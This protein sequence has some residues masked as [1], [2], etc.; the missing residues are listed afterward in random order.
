MMMA[1]HSLLPQPTSPDIGKKDVVVFFVRRP[2]WSDCDL[3]IIET[4]RRSQPQLRETRDGR[5]ANQRR[6]LLLRLPCERRLTGIVRL[7]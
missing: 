6:L 4:P 1:K 5:I 7:F 3:G 2:V